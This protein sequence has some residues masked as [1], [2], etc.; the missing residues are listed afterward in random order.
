[1]SVEKDVLL[2]Q[3]EKEELYCLLQEYEKTKHDI[4]NPLCNEEYNQKRRKDF[5]RAKQALEN[6]LQDH[7]FH[8]RFPG[9]EEI[10]EFDLKTI[11]G[12]FVND[13][14]VNKREVYVLTEDKAALERA[15]N[16]IEDIIKH[17]QSYTPW[18]DE[19]IGE[20]GQIKEYIGKISHCID[21]L[22][23]IDETSAD[24]YLYTYFKHNCHN[25]S[26]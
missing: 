26:L 22:S 5:T 23:V 10:C 6:F 3:L 12:M 7:E 11:T 9:R 18:M 20:I 8:M 4:N 15:A 19:D 25:F 2:T 16:S 21:K 24:I 14:K 13:M 17:Y 1:M